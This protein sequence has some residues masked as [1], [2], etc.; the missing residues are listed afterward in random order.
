MLKTLHH[1]RWRE[2]IRQTHAVC[3][4]FS[5][6]LTSLGASKPHTR[7]AASSASKMS[8]IH[9]HTY[10]FRHAHVSIR[11]SLLG[12]LSSARELSVCS[13][14]AKMEI[15]KTPWRFLDVCGARTHQGVST[16]SQRLKRSTQFLLCRCCEVHL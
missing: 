8:T 1:A 16:R 9:V 14:E 7:R 2:I 13:F 5:I 10:I 6:P 15:S 11:P 3:N 4:R 12:S